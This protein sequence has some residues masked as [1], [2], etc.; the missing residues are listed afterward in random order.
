[1]T[2]MKP[3]GAHV[4][5]A[6]SNKNRKCEPDVETLQANVEIHQPDIEAFQPD[7]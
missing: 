5:H 6:V 7:I 1:M 3:H 2:G 4:W